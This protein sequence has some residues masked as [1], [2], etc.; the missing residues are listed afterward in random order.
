MAFENS[1]IVIDLSGW[2]KGVSLKPFKDAGATHVILRMVYQGQYVFDNWQL[3]EDVCYR[4]WY[5][6]ARALGLYVGGYALYC[7]GVDAADYQNSEDMLNAIDRAM[8]GGRYKPDFLFIDDEVNTWMEHGT[9]V[10][11]TPT[12]QVKG[13]RILVDKCWKRFRIVTGHYSRVTFMKQT[14]AYANE[15]TAWLDSVNRA[16]KCVP[17]WYADY[18][19]YKQVINPANLREFAT[20]LAYPSST[21]EDKYLSC[22]SYSLWDLWQVAGDVTTPWG[23]CDISVSRQPVDKFNLLFNLTTPIPPDDDDDG[24]DGGDDSALAERV[25]AMEQQLTALRA[26]FRA[27]RHEMGAPVK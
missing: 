22:G 13:V 12:N 6:Q 14:P 25:T 1:A 11:A 7:A 21:M 3:T 18:L 15:Y 10:T 17:N 5:D 26:E 16:D 24:D 8:G 2:E 23:P 19:Y 20:N 4:G 9:R 27:H